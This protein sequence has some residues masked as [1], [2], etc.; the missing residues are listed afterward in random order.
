MRK[1]LFLLLAFSLI[2]T[3][4]FKHSE[5]PFAVVS[6]GTI[7]KENLQR[8]E[9]VFNTGQRINYALI[10]PDGVKYEGIR[11]QLSKQD[12]KVTNWGFS[13]IESKDIYLNKGSD[14]VYTDYLVPRSSGR[15][16][17]QFFY[18]NKKTYPFARREFVV[19]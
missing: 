6:S 15:Y 12:D 17:L 9:R 19:Q 10:A 18:L 7:N 8:Y 16:A 1:I 4:G 13:I 11:I 14:T 2:F 3:C 5:K